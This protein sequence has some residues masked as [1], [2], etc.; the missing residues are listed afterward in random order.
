MLRWELPGRRPGERPE[1]FMD[2]V[3]EDMRLVGVRG[4]RRE[5]KIEINDL[6]W[7]P[8][9]LAAKKEEKKEVSR[10][11]KRAIKKAKLDYKNKVEVSFTQGNLRS[12][13]QGLKNMAAVNCTTSSRKPIQVDGCSTTS[14]PDDLSSFFSRFERD[15]N[16][17]LKTFISSVHP[18]DP[19]IT[20]SREEV[21]RA[22]KRTKLNTATGPDNI[23]GRT[24]KYCAEQ[25]GEVFQQLFQTSMNCSTVPLKW[26]HS[27]IIPIPKKG[28]T[29]VLNDLRPVAL[30]SLVMKAME[31]IVK[32]SITQYVEPL[33]DPLQFAYRAG[34]G[35]DDAKIFILETIHTHLETPNTIARLLFADFSSAFNTMQ[36][37]ILAD[38]LITCFNLDYQLTMWI[39]DFLT[40]RSQR[41]LVNGSFSNIV[42]TSTGSPQGC[43]LSP[44][45]Y[46]LYT[47]DCRSTQPNCHLVKF[48]D[49]TVLLSLLSAPNLHHSSVLQDFITWCEGACLQLNSTKTKELIITFSSKQ[50][51][52]AEAVTTIIRGEPVEVVE[53]YRYLGTIFDGLLKFTSNIEEIIRNFL[54]S[55]LVHGM[56]VVKHGFGQYN[57]SGEQ[58]VFSY[59]LLLRFSHISI[60]TM[61]CYAPVQ[62]I[63]IE[64]VQNEITCSSEGIYPEPGLTWTTNPPSS[65][66]LQNPPTVQQTEQQLYSISS[67]LILSDRDTD[68]DYICTVSTPA[69]SR[70]STL[71]R[72]AVI[73]ASNIERKIPC[74]TAN[75]PIRYLTW[76]FNHKEIILTQSG[77]EGHY[78]TSERWKQHVMTVSETGSLTLKHLSSDQTGTYKC[79]LSDEE[80][81]YVKYTFLHIPK[82]W[83]GVIVGVVMV[84]LLV[85]LV[86]GVVGYKLHKYRKRWKERRR[87]K[88]I[89]EEEVLVQLGMEEQDYTEG[90]RQRPERR[91]V[92]FV[93][94]KL[95]KTQYKVIASALKSNPSHMTELDLSQ[96]HLED[97][98]VKLLSDGLKSPKCTLETLR[99]EKCSLSEISCSSLV[100]ALKSNPSHLKHLDLSDNNLQD[101]G[102][103]HLCGFLESPDCRLETLSF[104]L[105]RLSEISCSSL[106]S[107]LKSN[108]SHLKLLDLSNNNLQDSGVKHLCGFLESPDC[109]LETLRLENCRLSEIS[110]SYLVLA[111]KSNP[112]HLKHLDLSNNNLQDSGVK[113]LCGF[114]ES[115]DCRLETLRLVDCSLSEISCSSLVSA[116]KSNP[117]HLKHLDVNKNYDLQDSGVK[118]LCGFLE[119]PDC[120]LETLSLQNCNLSEISCSSLVSSLKSNPSHLKHLDLSY[121]YLQNLGV[122]HLCG[123]LESPDCRLETLRLENCSLSEISCSS[124]V[125][126]LKS[127]PSHLKHLELSRNKNMQDSGVKHLCG[128]LES[129][130]CRL[131]T[132]RLVDCSLSK[133]SCSSL[134]SALKSNPS[135]LKLLDLSRN[136]NLQDSG[137]KHLCGFLESPDC[138]LE[139]LRLEFCSLS[140][141][142]CSS[143]V[144]ALNS[145][146][147]HL[148][149]LDLSYNNLQDSDVKQLSDLVKS[150][151]Y[152]LQTIRIV[153][154]GLGPAASSSCFPQ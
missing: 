126:F 86:S 87:R 74:S 110:C 44:L 120:R 42:H 34:R 70:R 152:K 147:S 20:F 66:N 45:L 41:V 35:V 83:T 53:E 18:D 91:E 109:R 73:S 19:S 64:Q 134:V 142:S 118:H 14:L 137:V 48:A 136:K 90:V 16:T 23:C 138:R 37:H 71:L 36:P 30:T 12:A 124:L 98:G 69:N 132:L 68:L 139:T 51:Q 60:V 113:H 63:N 92:R 58:Q 8:L 9:T 13:W 148:K 102:V 93:G 56:M 105:C 40:N 26:K 143:L 21:V 116:L 100:S 38:K 55:L 89:E 117:S 104:V 99:L 106:V 75:Y 43:V 133:D 95:S 62:H 6:L 129:P 15:N 3:K 123:F 52:L 11:V 17:E 76:T 121:N 141:V 96:N 81:T 7:Q 29:K 85:V 5:R 24:L 22:L 4:R 150:P 65:M 46:I 125:S 149:L 97:S 57:S 119:S 31:R 128:F 28:P 67:S 72:P 103:E 80:E 153:E 2:A 50:R 101:S 77:D 144:S 114:L 88:K 111:L 108:P 10:E 94:C 107:A 78:I 49:D 127:N 27:T 112:S 146:P 130:G 84:V 59:A 122:I 115:P 151:D 145:N 61:R 82:D 140:G 39:I 25:L 79:E 1:R 54:S 32:N 47:N 135:H 131:E 154:F 33:M